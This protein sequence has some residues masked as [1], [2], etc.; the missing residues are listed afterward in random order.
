MAQESR[1][2]DQVI[3]QR[4]REGDE[5]AFATIYRQHVQTLFRYGMSIQA[6]EDFIQDC[7]HD[8]FVE[9]W[10]KRQRVSDTNSIKYY[11]IKSLKNR[12][13]SQL[14]KRQRLAPTSLGPETPA[15]LSPSHEDEWIRGQDE[16]RLLTKLAH[17]LDRLPPRQRE[18]LQLRFFE[19][20]DYRQVAEVLV[21]SQQSAYNLIFR[22]LEEL[23]KQVLTG[24]LV[25]IFFLF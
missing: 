6:D 21:V 17:G 5:T 18:A 16:D 20:L 4:F 13:F 15:P 24:S 8:V 19:G 14:E 23:R 7:I 9:I 2:D 10:T 12:I 22:A 1:P 11:F 25:G 3:W